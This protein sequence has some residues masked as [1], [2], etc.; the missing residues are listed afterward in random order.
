DSAYCPMPLRMRIWQ[1]LATDL[2]PA[3]LDELMWREIALDELPGAL[4]EILAGR[5]RGRIVVR[6]S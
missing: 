4:E 6:L 2:R 3:H 1:R 5:V